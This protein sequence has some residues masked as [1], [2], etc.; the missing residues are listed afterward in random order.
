[1]FGSVARAKCTLFQV[2]TLESWSEGIARPG[3]TGAA[4]ARG[5][6]HPHVILVTAGV[7]NVIVATLVEDM[8][9]QTLVENE[10]TLVLQ[11]VM[12]EL[13]GI[14]YGAHHPLPGVW[15]LGGRLVTGRVAPDPH[16]HFI[17][18]CGP[19]HPA[20]WCVVSTTVA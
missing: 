2:L 13:V 5:L 15:F 19:S 12:I 14:T 4:G 18:G 11:A 16:H 6:R 17:A 3:V 8:L 1:M 7:L 10:E 9:R 20:V